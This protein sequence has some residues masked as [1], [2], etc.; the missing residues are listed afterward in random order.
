MH[1]R[2]KSQAI[3][4]LEAI[5]EYY[6]AVAPEFADILT[7][8]ILLKTRRLLHSPQSGRIVPEID[9]PSIREILVYSYRIIYHYSA[10]E[11]NI[12]ILTVYH[13][14]RDL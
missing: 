7:D 6:L 9:D 8:E 13:S 5:E 10:G 12:E 11:S 14:A 2:W 3:K 1:I 4:D